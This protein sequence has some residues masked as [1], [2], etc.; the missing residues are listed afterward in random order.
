MKKY[1][2]LVAI[3]ISLFV[4]LCGI[5]YLFNIIQ[6]FAKSTG[7]PIGV[8]KLDGL[9]LFLFGMALGFYSFYKERKKEGVWKVNIKR[10][11]ILGLPSLFVGSFI[12]IY[13]V[14]VRVLLDLTDALAPF[15][16]NSLIQFIGMV[17]SGFVLMTSFY[18]KVE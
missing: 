18:K 4:A 17:F 11:I 8:Y 1:L 12:F 16:S 3:A 9:I 2:K 10:L 7:D 15:L 6:N 5:G 14:N 13:Y